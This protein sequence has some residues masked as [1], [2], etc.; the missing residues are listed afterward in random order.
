MNSRGRAKVWLTVG[1]LAERYQ[2]TTKAVYQ[3]RHR[4]TGPQGVKIGR[5][6]LFDL[7]EVERWET[8]RI[9]AEAFEAYREAARS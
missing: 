3:W 5:K 7:A 6:V 9:T 8:W 2:T 1:Q 4:R